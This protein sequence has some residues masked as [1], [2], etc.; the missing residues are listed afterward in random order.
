MWPSGRS[1]HGP[2]SSS[3]ATGLSGRSGSLP[4]LRYF[5]AEKLNPNVNP[6]P[7]DG[8]VDIDYG[9]EETSADQ[10]EL[11]GGWGYGRI[12]GTLGL[13]FNNFSLQTIL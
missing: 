2:G 8:T 1:R 13:S 10:I 6:K 11:S 9:V 7:E 12:V 5:D 3:A 4:A